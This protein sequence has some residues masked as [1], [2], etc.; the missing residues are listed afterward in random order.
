MEGEEQTMTRDFPKAAPPLLGISAVVRRLPR[1]DGEADVVFLVALGDGTTRSI[2]M[3]QLALER[4]DLLLHHLR[5]VEFPP[6][7]RGS[8]DEEF[9]EELLSIEDPRDLE[10]SPP[11]AALPTAFN[12]AIEASKSSSREKTTKTSRIHHLYQ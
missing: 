12:G 9:G 6:D 5:L 2:S 4:A 10:Q 3:Y 7:F 1:S 8:S 11:K